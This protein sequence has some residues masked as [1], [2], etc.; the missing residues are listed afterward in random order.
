MALTSCLKFDYQAFPSVPNEA[1]PQKRIVVRPVITMRLFFNE[2]SVRSPALIDSGS[3]FCMFH[4]EIGELLGI[5]IRSGKK[6]V[7]MGT[8]GTPQHAYF[9]TVHYDIGGWNIQSYAGFSYEMKTMPYGLLGQTGFFNQFRI[10]FDYAKKRIEMK[11][12]GGI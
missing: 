7:F 11:P 12:K 4:A 8:G 10:E 6:M 9:H 3:D 5:N 1:F 2:K